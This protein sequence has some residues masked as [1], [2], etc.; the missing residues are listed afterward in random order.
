M[1]KPDKILT[2]E[3]LEREVL[4]MGAGRIVGSVVDFVLTRD[5]TVS[6][7]GILPLTWYRGGQGIEPCNIVSINEERVCI[8][9]SDALTNFEPD[10]EETFSMMSGSQIQGKAVLQQDGEELGLLVDLAFNLADGRICDLVV[11]D[12]EEKRVRVAVEAIH[13]IGP[14][15]IVVERATTKASAPEPEP[16]PVAKEPEPAPTPEPPPP[17]K[18]DK[19]AAKKKSSAPKPEAS[20]A[21]KEAVA[22]PEEG[23]NGAAVDAVSVPPEL[24]EA[25]PP[26]PGGDA[27]REPTRTEE[28]KAL[29]GE[30]QPA[31]ELSKFDQKKRDFLLGRPA[32]REIKTPDGDLI[33][34]AGDVLDEKALS[35]IIKHNLLANVFLE[36]TVNK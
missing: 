4:D 23:G 30:S 29:F 10:S 26:L 18:Q 22:D 16:E 32:R 5:G 25:P 20:V 34:K 13:T 15:Y 36:M 2:A 14:D 11:L 19:P 31:A 9:G 33:A 24:E 8:S 28:K 6:L 1:S 3:L 21:K 27:E 35:R 17:P 7:V 12:A